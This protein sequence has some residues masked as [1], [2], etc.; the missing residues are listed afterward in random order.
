MKIAITGHTAGIGKAFTQYL[1]LRGH[2]IVGLS[3]RDG[4]NIRNVPKIV[5][6]IIDCDMWI[7]NAQSGYAQTELLHRV[8]DVWGNDPAKM[9]WII[10]TIM[11]Q[12]KDLPKIPDID[13]LTLM[14]YRNQKRA[15]ED[16]F[17]S[18]KHQKMAMCL[19]RPGT[20]A[21][22][23]WNQPGVDSAD[24]DSWAAAVCDFYLAARQNNL[25]IEEISLRFRNQLPCL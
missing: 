13:T 12:D 18:L 9:I 24:V 23:V 19:I 3:K 4:N 6:K 21:T 22:Q 8:A 7:N 11:T 10:S 20:V 16:A 1:S 14:E 15:L 2:E 17:Y 25:W 5:E